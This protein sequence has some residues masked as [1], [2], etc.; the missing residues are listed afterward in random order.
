MGVLEDGTPYLT[1]RSL[2]RLCGVVPSAVIK[3][4]AN[5]SAGQR[6][7]RLAQM[8]AEQGYEADDL[9][10]KTTHKGQ[11]VHAYPDG[12]CMAFLEYYAFESG[13][14]EVARNNY[15]TLAR[16]TLR[17]FIYTALDYDPARSVLKSWQQFHDRLLLN[18]APQGFFSVFKEIADVVLAAIK[19]GLRVDHETVPDISVGRGWS[20]HWKDNALAEKYGEREQHP[21]IYPDYFPQAVMNPVDAFVYPNEALGA[22]RNWLQGEYLVL[23]FPK[24]LRGKVAKGAIAADRAKLFLAEIGADDDDEGDKEGS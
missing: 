14:S 6:T 2:A 24:Y 10:I 3:Q 23:S 16:R 17:T 1:G 19:G 18:N 21:H 7:G 8:L 15:R 4:A 9:Y 13:S 5:W 20:K 22:F 12:V 11:E